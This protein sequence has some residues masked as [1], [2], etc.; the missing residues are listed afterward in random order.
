M[1]A[2]EKSENKSG[3]WFYGCYFLSSLL[4]PTVTRLQERGLSS[5]HRSITGPQ[6]SPSTLNEINHYHHERD[7]QQNV[8]D[9]AQGVG[10][11]H[12]K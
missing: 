11:D 12:A 2:L 3:P 5:V 4:T 10:G 7:D 6:Q 9:S 1:L 8:N